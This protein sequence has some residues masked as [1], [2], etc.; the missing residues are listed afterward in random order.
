MRRLWQSTA[1][2]YFNPTL[3]LILTLRSL[4]CCGQTLKKYAHIFAATSL[5]FNPTLGLILTRELSESLYHEL[6]FQ[7][8]LRSDSDLFEVVEVQLII[9]FQSYLRSDSDMIVGVILFYILH[10]FNPTLGLILTQ[11]NYSVQLRKAGI[12]ILP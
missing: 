11:C 5:H 8:Y 6:V 1:C 3:G 2:G 10:D 7:S 12:S 9:E 4:S